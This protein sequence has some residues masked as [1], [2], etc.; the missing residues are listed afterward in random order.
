MEIEEKELSAV[1]P[2]QQFVVDSEIR[3]LRALAAAEVKVPTRGKILSIGVAPGR[4]VTAGDTV[5]SLVDCDKRFVVAIF[6]YR[7]GQSMK[8][9]TLVRVDG[10]SFGSGIVTAV[11]P[12]TSD[13]LD[14]RFAIPFPQTERRE[15][16]AMISPDA[17]TDDA[18]QTD[19]ADLREQSTPCSV[20][21]WVTVTK[22]N[23]MVPSMSVAWR[24]IEALLTPRM[25]N[26]PTKALNDGDGK[27]EAGIG[28]LSSAMRSVAPEAR[29]APDLKDWM[30]R[31]D[32][33]V[34]R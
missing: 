33:F 31:A 26:N 25:S 1:L 21:Q 8:V 4:H 18:P 15:L 20:G 10:A 17:K 9:G 29:H 34:S 11:L 12:K 2:T 5:A 6:S 32:D 7:Q 24:R 14:E 23:G 30:D 19:T 16:Y 3:R 22:E 13:K 28:V 27:R